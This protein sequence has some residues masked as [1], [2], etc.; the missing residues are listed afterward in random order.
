MA[1]L[2][3]ILMIVGYFYFI[4]RYNRKE[5]IKQ[6]NDLLDNLSKGCH[7]LDSRRFVGEL[8]WI[9]FQLFG[10]CKSNNSYHKCYL[11]DISR[12]PHHGSND[13]FYEMLDRHVKPPRILADRD[14]G[15][16]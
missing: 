14:A 1:V 8:R 12:C 5:L 3:I 13:A 9:D 7:Y 4:T 11:C 10:G 6:R 2:I 15:L 16:G